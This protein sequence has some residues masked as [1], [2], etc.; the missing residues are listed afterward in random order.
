MFD[1]HLLRRPTP[2][3]SS[4]DLLCVISFLILYSST[5]SDMNKMCGRRVRPTRYAP[6][7][8]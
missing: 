4:A 7:C 2:Q 6:A 3:I 1:E 5:I 8:L